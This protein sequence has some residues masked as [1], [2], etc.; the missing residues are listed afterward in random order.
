MSINVELQGGFGNHLL[1]YFLGCILAHKY[2]MKLSLISNEIPND[3]LDQRSDTRTTIFKVAN[4]QFITP[5][6]NRGITI[7]TISMY[8]S[9]LSYGLDKYSNYTITFITDSLS[10]YTSHI[11]N[12]STYL[13]PDIFHVEEDTSTSIIVSLRLG[14]GAAEVAQPSP[15]EKELRLP[16]TYYRDAILQCLKLYPT[17]KTLIILSDNYS[18]P[19]IEQFQEFKDLLKIIQYS[20]KNTYEQFKC[21]I[22]AHFF[23][24]SNSSF[25]LVGSLLNTKGTVMIPNFIESDSP[26]PG[27][28]NKRYST[29]LN[30]D[31]SNSVKVSIS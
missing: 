7:D 15:F 9:L 27:S 26:Y 28:D 14:M 10:F 18:S 4:K 3:T 13:I 8:K 29:I 17:K 1:T 11:N 31:T 21:I 12:I 24:S 5:F 19:Y 30:I 22:N 2:D 25:S 6:I 20:N 16:F 23:I